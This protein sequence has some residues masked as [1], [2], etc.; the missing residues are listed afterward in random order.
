VC[1]DTSPTSEN[2]PRNR[3]ARWLAGRI[4]AVGARLFAAEDLAATQHGWQITQRRGGM[5]RSYRDPRFDTLRSCPRCHGS[6]ATDGNPCIPCDA[7]GRVS[8]A[9]PSREDQKP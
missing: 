6:G 8:L 5:G 1:N 2:K 7:T 3:V 4:A 9:A